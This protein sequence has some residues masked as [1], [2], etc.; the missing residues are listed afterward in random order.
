MILLVCFLGVTE[1]F[2]GNT[3]TIAGKARGSSL[4]L[5]T[6]CCDFS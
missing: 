4:Q 6:S 3:I 2:S 5:A 1:G